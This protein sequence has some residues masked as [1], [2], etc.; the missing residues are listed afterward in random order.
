MPIA[1]ATT[2]SPP[3][4]SKWSKKADSVVAAG[5]MYDFEYNVDL[6]LHDRMGVRLD[7]SDD[8]TIIAIDFLK[9]ISRIAGA[10]EPQGFTGMFIDD[11]EPVICRAVHE[12][13]TQ[14]R[15]TGVWRDKVVFSWEYRTFNGKD[16]ILTAA[17]DLFPR[18]PC[19]NFRLLDPKPEIQTPYADLSYVQ[20]HFAFD[21]D[22][23]GASGVVNLVKTTEGFRIWTLH[24]AIES[25]HQFPE[26]PNRDGHM[27]GP[28]SWLAQRELDTKFEH[29]QPDV[30]IIGGGHK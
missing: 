3:P 25:L 6:P 2:P 12:I 13:L 4:S 7:A 11:G 8:A 10:P 27:V 26:L 20:V 23:A 22:V 5:F 19:T 21:T 15:S 16:N 24:T 18:T 14:N 17:T 9:S 28:L 30:V 1:I 29:A